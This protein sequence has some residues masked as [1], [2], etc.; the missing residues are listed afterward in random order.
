[1]CP[2]T[3][4]ATHK[5]T[6]ICRTHTKVCKLTVVGCTFCEHYPLAG[7][8]RPF[9]YCLI[10]RGNHNHILHVHMYK[11]AQAC[12]YPTPCDSGSVLKSRSELSWY[13]HGLWA[14][15]VENCSYSMESSY[16][17]NLPKVCK[18]QMNTLYYLCLD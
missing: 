6:S 14:S 9:V 3:Q 2:S 12:M 18:Q 16:F 17:S 5:N 4:C 8:S 13:L 1:M 7:I 15:L 11:P 10:G